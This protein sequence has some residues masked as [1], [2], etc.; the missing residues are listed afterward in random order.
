[1][2]IYIYMYRY[3]WYMYVYRAKWLAFLDVYRCD[4]YCY[5]LCTDCDT[6]FSSHEPYITFSASARSHCTVQTAEVASPP[7][8]RGNKSA[9]EGTCN[10]SFV[11]G[12]THKCA[13]WIL[14]GWTFWVFIA[15]IYIHINLIFCTLLVSCRIASWCLKRRKNGL[16]LWLSVA[17]TQH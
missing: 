16:F 6:D 12:N 17:D 4:G 13:F 11:A 9:N 8:E 7:C 10:A 1:M 15:Y 3:V 5:Q 2:Q 14:Y